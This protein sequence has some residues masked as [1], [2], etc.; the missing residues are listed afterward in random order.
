MVSDMA[1]IFQ[2]KVTPNASKNEILRFDKEILQVWIKGTPEK[3][4]VNQERIQFLAK[5]FKV[6]KSQI[7]I[8]S[9]KTSRMKKLKIEKDP[10]IEWDYPP[11]SAF[12]DKP[13]PHHPDED[14]LDDM[15]LESH[16]FY[17]Q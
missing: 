16:M 5:E 2:I 10:K 12:Q 9:G 7:Q 14:W 4:K 17:S 3:G 15:H 1:I 11:F 13:S 8:L 6:G